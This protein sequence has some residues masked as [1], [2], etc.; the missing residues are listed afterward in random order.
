MQ[1]KFQLYTLHSQQWAL[2]EVIL[3]V[4]QNFQHGK[5]VFQEKSFVQLDIG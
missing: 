4:A 5:V 1:I 3:E 2:C